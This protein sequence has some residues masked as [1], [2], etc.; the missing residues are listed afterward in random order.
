M[1]NETD[2]N[3]KS[4]RYIDKYR[5]STTI[6]YTRPDVPNM[7][8]SR[9]DEE[10]STKIKTNQ[11]VNQNHYC[12]PRGLL[13]FWKSKKKWKYGSSSTVSHPLHNFQP[14]PQED[15]NS[16]SKVI[17]VSLHPLGKVYQEDWNPTVLSSC[18]FL[19]VNFHTKFEEELE[20]S[21]RQNLKSPGDINNLQLQDVQGILYLIPKVV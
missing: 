6:L 5:K 12:S 21:R 9:T 8:V 3:S 10:N 2:E 4:I 18:R 1:C 17:T 16:K 20:I 7:Y 19:V 13:T 11:S 15:V 14:D